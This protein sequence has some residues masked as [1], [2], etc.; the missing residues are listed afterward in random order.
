MS[1]TLN[2]LFYNLVKTTENELLETDAKNIE[3]VNPLPKSE[4]FR[5]LFIVFIIFFIF[6]KVVNGIGLNQIFSLIISIFAIY[7]FMQNYKTELGNRSHF[8]ALQLNFL[9]EI[10]LQSDYTNTG[11]VGDID[12]HYDESYLHLE[13]KYVDFFYRT[14][15]YFR[16][17]SKQ[18]RDA[19][20][21]V[22]EFIRLK[23]EI[24]EGIYYRKLKLDI[25]VL[26][27]ARIKALN[28]FKSIIYTIPPAR[29]TLDKVYNDTKV[30]H[31]L[32]TQ[33]IKKVHEMYKEK[34]LDPKNINIYTSSSYQMDVDLPKANDTNSVGFMPN[35]NSY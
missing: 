29:Y 15:E 27:D 32:L 30:L 7:Y 8:R 4:K 21:A 3:R 34:Y 10:L 11:T 23:K 9:D 17:A 16:Y 18:Y 31:K 19:L 6:S 5:Y 35:F 25:N 2:K 12:P 24:K 22:N 14:R 33:D 26:E 20:R 1:L 13:P 28:H